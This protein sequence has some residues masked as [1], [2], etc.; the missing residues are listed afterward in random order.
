MNKQ[1][2]D[3][4][5]LFRQGADLSHAELWLRYFELGGMSNGIQLE[6]YLY[7]VLQPSAHDH[8]VIAQALNERFTELGEDHPVPYVED[9]N[10]PNGAAS[11]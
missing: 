3:A 5:E 11:G 6:A 8:D 2:V 10:Y 1:T 9:G 4:L 7:G